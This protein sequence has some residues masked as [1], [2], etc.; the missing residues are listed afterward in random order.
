[1]T[2][3]KRQ[4]VCPKIFCYLL[5]LFRDWTSVREDFVVKEKGVE[6]RQVERNGGENE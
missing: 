6:R 1:M 4:G 5:I 2:A 3:V